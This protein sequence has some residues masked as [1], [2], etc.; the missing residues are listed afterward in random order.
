MKV[1][2]ILLILHDVT[3][4]LV[5]MQLLTVEGDFVSPDLKQD[6]AIVA[7]VEEC[8]K[9]RGVVFQADVDK[10]I[11]ALPLVLALIH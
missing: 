8:A 11:N 2:T 4:K 5:G 10:I 3:E 9:A 1:G 7:M 6:V